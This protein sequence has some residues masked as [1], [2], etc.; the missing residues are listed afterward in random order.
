MVEPALQYRFQAA[1]LHGVPAAGIE[2][3]TAARRLPDQSIE[4][5]V[6]GPRLKSLDFLYVAVAAGQKDKPGHAAKMQ[7]DAGFPRV[8]EE[9]EIGE[10]DQRRSL[11]TRRYIASAK[12]V[13]RGDAR[14]FCHDGGHANAQRG[15]ESS[16]RIMP[17]RVTSAA[18]ALSSVQ[19]E[20]GLVGNLAGGSGEC[21]TEKP[22][23]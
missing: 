14:A 15:G 20:T 22:M 3:L 16:F 18:D 21:F 10:G 2:P 19:R 1:A 9:K 13:D 11:S 23:K 12:I 4:K 5:N 6:A 7:Q 17:D 8:T